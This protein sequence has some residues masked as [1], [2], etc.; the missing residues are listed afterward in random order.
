MSTDARFGLPLRLADAL[1]QESSAGA[2]MLGGFSEQR[3]NAKTPSPGRWVGPRLAAAGAGAAAALVA[4]AHAAVPSLQGRWTMDPAQSQF[5]EPLTGPAPDS[6][7]VVVARDTPQRLQYQLV[8][9]RGGVEIGHAA[10]ALSFSGGPSVSIADGRKRKVS[11][12]RDPAGAVV[13]FGPK[14]ANARVVIR[15]Q[16]TGPDRAVLEHDLEAGGRSVPIERIALV[17]SGEVA[18]N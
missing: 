10:Y 7:T 1:N 8:E 11:A 5:Y 2:A 16:P 14:T 15:L 17:R 18:S 4:Q 13:V 6:V 12:A 9:R 3:P